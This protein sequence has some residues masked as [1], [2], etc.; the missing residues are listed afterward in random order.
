MSAPSL[1][2]MADPLAERLPPFD[3]EAERA[4]L[5]TG[6]VH[7]ESLDL[8]HSLVGP[9]DFRLEG[10]ARIYRAML[11]MRAEG[12]PID[13][14]TL[15]NELATRGDLE[16]CGGLP[17]LALLFDGYWQSATVEEYAR[18]VA[19]KSRLRRL[20]ALCQ[21][22]LSDLYRQRRTSEQVAAALQDGALD[23]LGARGGRAFQ[24]LRVLAPATWEAIQQ[25][26]TAGAMPG[27]P[28]GY[29]AIDNHTAGGPAPGDL[30]YVA[31]RPK[32]GKT[33]WLGNVALNASYRGHSVAF[34]S[35]EMPTE[36]IVLRLY[37]I[38]SGIDLMALRTGV[39]E[40]AHQEALTE[41]MGW[42][43]ELPLD[44]AD[45]RTLGDC[46]VRSLTLHLRRLMADLKRQG[47]SLGLV[48]IDQL[49][50]IAPERHGSLYET[51]T[52][53]ST[54]LKQM[55]LA[56]N[57]P[58]ICLHQLN[59]NIEREDREPRL[60]D[61]RDSGATEA[62]ADLIAF[63]HREGADQ[64]LDPTATYPVHFIAKVQRNGP[65]F[66]LKLR[67][68]GRTTR[69]LEEETHYA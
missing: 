57:V 39:L 21:D 23:A 15:K 20:I 62:D 2:A 52:A 46:T 17:Y 54:G 63:L 6:L 16:Q 37:A 66:R 49:N 8:A 55:A 51:T 56:L 4:V 3:E 31:A 61:L 64:D 1:S 24:P 33:A 34:A 35:L 26:S 45:A 48:A 29:Y 41:A 19:E 38:K 22:Q 44:I 30:W 53:A 14:L 25:R 10:H 5:G 68:E 7:N 43:S 12:R 69:F 42:L 11:D 36:Q 67:L 58:V 59:R 13:V 9:E 40:D 32:V 60:D 47:K 50:K 18:T 65:P 27:T 28:T